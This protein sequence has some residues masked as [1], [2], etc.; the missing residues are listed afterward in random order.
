MTWEKY[1]G[2]HPWTQ[3]LFDV[4]LTQHPLLLVVFL[5]PHT[6]LSW[7]QNTLGVERVLD[8]LVELHQCVVVE[9]VRHGNLIHETYMGSE[10][11]PSIVGTVLNH[12]AHQPLHTL[13]HVSIFAVKDNTDDIVWDK[14]SKYL[15]H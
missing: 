12:G 5:R 15:A 4:V 10:F 14:V 7:S 11:S 9:V 3:Y 8:R 2:I 6:T 1:L 13:T